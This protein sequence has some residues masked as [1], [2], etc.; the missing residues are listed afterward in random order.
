M[1]LNQVDFFIVLA[2]ILDLSFSFCLA[3]L[4]TDTEEN[5]DSGGWGRLFSLLR[6]VR[7]FRLTKLVRTF[8]AAERVQRLLLTLYQSFPAMKNVGGVLLIL[9]YT[10][11][12]L[13]TSLFADAE[14]RGEI[15]QHTNFDSFGSAMM[16][17]CRISTGEGWPAV[18]QSLVDGLKDDHLD[19]HGNF[20]EGNGAARITGPLF[21]FRSSSCPTSSFSIF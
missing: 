9:Y 13:G 8:K 4:A 17:L 10:F 18:L 2:S 7:I 21:S 20:I 6:F 5:S 3:F 16:T 1:F 11:A 15:D 14:R 12:V 19:R